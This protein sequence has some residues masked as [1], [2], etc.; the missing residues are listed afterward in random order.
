[1]LQLLPVRDAASLVLFSDLVTEGTSSGDLI[2]DAVSYP[3]YQ[4]LRRHNDLFQDLCAF[5]EGEDNVIMHVSGEPETQVGYASLHLVSGNYFDVLDVQA[6]AGRLLR[7]SDDRPDAA[8]VAVMTYGLWKNRFHLDPGVLG[9]AV[10]LNGTTFTVAGVT[11]ASFFGERIRS[12]PDF[13]VPLSF[14]PQ[15]T[16]REQSLLSAND[17]YWLNCMGRLKRGVTLKAAQA[18]VNAQLHSFY[19]AQAGTRL[20]A[21]IRHKVDRVQIALKPGGSGISGLRYRYSK[22]L[23]VLMAVVALVLLIA[24]AN[25]AIL[26]LARASARRQEFL[27]RLALG[28]ASAR[29]FRQVLTES[30]LL[31]LIG[32]LAGGG[33]AWW[34]VRALVVLL[35]FDAVVKVKPDPNVLAFSIALSIATGILFGII[36]A[37]QF[38]RLDLRPGSAKPVSWR[39]RCLLS[40]SKTWASRAIT[41]S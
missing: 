32:G 33:F 18:A 15:A 19:L 6:A 9:K 38:S 41:S 3:F 36:P 10:V 28:A 22:P 29:V 24:C 26:L 21:D 23:T 2:G 20:S 37:W 8:P 13:W 1:M 12:S 35:H 17:H 14:E 7:D 30:I 11:D 27:C 25:L 34:S 39:A 5:R 40:K 31:S 4:D 16:T